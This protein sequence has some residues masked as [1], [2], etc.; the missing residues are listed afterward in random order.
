MV[1]LIEYLY[2]NELKIIC[3]FEIIPYLCSFSSF[4]SILNNNKLK[5]YMEFNDNYNKNLKMETI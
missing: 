2:Y 4:K 1:I 3:Q 5:N